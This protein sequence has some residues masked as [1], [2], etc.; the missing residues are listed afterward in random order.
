MAIVGVV[1][2]Y[3]MLEAKLKAP[4]LTKE[5]CQPFR[6]TG[7]FLYSANSRICGLEHMSDRKKL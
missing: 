3:Y 5:G 4:L 6:L 7:P 2:F 1:W